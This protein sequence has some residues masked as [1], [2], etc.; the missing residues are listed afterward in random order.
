M[1]LRVLVSGVNGFIGQ[2]IAR[3]LISDGH[4]V[5]GVALENKPALTH[6]RLTYQQLDITD[7]AAT[8]GLLRT[9]PVDAIIHLAALVHVQ[10]PNLTFVDYAR[11]N[12]R[13]SEALFSAAL[14]V[15]VTRLIFASTVEVYG[16]TPD[17]T[18]VDEQV[19]CHPESDYARSKL[20]AEESL[21]SL[22]STRGAAFAILR[23]APVYAPG[24]RLNLDK[25]L[26]LK[27]PRLSYIVGN[28]KYNL[29]LCSLRNIEHWV[30]HWISQPAPI[31]G[32]FNLADV[33]SYGVRELLRI[34]RAHGHAQLTVYLPTFPCLT[35]LAVRETIL[36]T[37]GRS[38]G[39]Y[40]TGNFR[41][42]ARSV[43]WDTRQA[44][45]AVGD[46]PG[47]L[48][49]DLYGSVTPR[50]PGTPNFDLQNS[51][52][53]TNDKCDDRYERTKRMLDIFLAAA[54]L[55]V[56][57]VP[58]TSIAAVIRLTSP[59]PAIHW[60]RR[61]GRDNREF[62]MPKFRTMRVDTPQLPTH[63]MT[64]SARFVTPIGRFLRRT[65]LDELPQL[66]SIIRGDMSFVGPRPALFNQDDLKKFR[67]ERGVQHLTPGLTGWAQVN[68][69]DE[70]P[71]PDK[72][73]YDSYY[74]AHR[75][76][77]FDLQILAKTFLKAS[78]GEGVSH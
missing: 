30:R 12:Y 65:S 16:R 55:A 46:L 71:I 72:V 14:D 27:A 63:L 51:D 23:F 17:G 38:A 33:K 76:L 11:V 7:H 3:A 73:A 6:T 53:P 31:S 26:Y 15:G 77:R 10:D 50:V 41:K 8:L 62:K 34:E 44:R 57:A 39:M 70:L 43:Q 69:R 24:F 19:P 61:I 49:Q 52:S 13:A 78:V 32:T 35:A 5:L 9:E 2:H 25:R 64:D 48:E 1:V 36:A 75:S 37:A 22:A 45:L 59:G 74:L 58:L 66:L 40:S 29:S 47:D 20:L 56:L 18:V 67:S 68:G 60:S 4:R 28:G 42:L 54:G 21:R